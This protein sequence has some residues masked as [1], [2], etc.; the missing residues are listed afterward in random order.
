MRQYGMFKA[1]FMSFYSKD[2]YRDVVKNWGGYA[3]LYLLLL[4]AISW[5]PI[6]AEMQFMLNHAYDNESDKIIQQIPVLTIVNGKIRTPEKRPYIIKSIDNDKDRLVV[7]DTSGKYKT[8]EEAQATM[9]ITE[10][11]V[12]TQTK[13]DEMR[14]NTVPANWNV[15]LDPQVINGF[16]KKYLGYSWVLLFPLFILL[17]FIYRFIQVL[18][19]SVIGKIMSAMTHVDLSYGQIMQIMMVALTPTTVACTLFSVFNV[20]FPYQGWLYFALAMVYLLLGIKAN[21]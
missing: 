12:L 5:V 20:N 10:T 13:P 1:F 16:I 11:E 6:T 19:Y 18:I 17:G 4:V 21:K 2:L 3:I 14:I 7:I 9:L 15:T 8:L